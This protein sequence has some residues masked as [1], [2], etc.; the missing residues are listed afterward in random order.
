MDG[1]KL[2]ENEVKYLDTFVKKGRRRARELTR[3]RVL[4]LVNQGRTEME[5]KDILEISRATV[6]NMNKTPSG[7]L[8]TAPAR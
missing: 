7:K 3:A 6:S 5:I 8:P 1:I 2:T 4:L